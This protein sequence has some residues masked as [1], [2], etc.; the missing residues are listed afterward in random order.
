VQRPS[1][2]CPHADQPRAGPSAVRTRRAD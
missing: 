2:V 1:L